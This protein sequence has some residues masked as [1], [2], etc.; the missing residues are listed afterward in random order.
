MPP[1]AQG[2]FAGDLLDGVS[3]GS[4]AVGDQN[5]QLLETWKGL[6]ES[7]G[8]FCSQLLENENLANT[9]FNHNGEERLVKVLGL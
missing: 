6:K 1:T 4:L 5:G 7:G 3:N 2:L 8:W 9:Y